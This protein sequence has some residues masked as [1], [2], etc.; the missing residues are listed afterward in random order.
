MRAPSAAWQCPEP[1]RDKLYPDSRTLERVPFVFHATRERRIRSIAGRGLLPKRQ[2]VCHAD[3]DRCTREAVVFFTPTED[4][5]YL[6]GDVLL[7]FPWPPD[8][9]RDRYSDC[10]MLEEGV[11]VLSSYFTHRPI[12]AREIEV[13]VGEEWVPIGEAA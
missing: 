7:R 4:M 10:I 1:W 8:I 2:P 9:H 3:E 5:A 6:W 12:P 11:F 13:L